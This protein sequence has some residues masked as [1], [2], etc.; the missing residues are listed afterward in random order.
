VTD[1]VEVYPLCLPIVV[2]DPE[3]GAADASKIEYRLF[4][5]SA[6]LQDIVKA[7]SPEVVKPA[8][9]S[10]V[11]RKQARVWLPGTIFII[12][13]LSLS[14]FHSLSQSCLHILSFILICQSRLFILF[15]HR[16]FGSLRFVVFLLYQSNRR[17]SRLQRR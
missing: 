16:E 9:D 12:L 13:L 7:F 4:T 14:L 8:D 6:K 3:T 17:M 10:Y 2:A 11:P 5:R 1:V 15:V